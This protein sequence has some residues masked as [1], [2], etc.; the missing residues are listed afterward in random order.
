[1]SIPLGWRGVAILAYWGN[2]FEL[3]RSIE[4]YTWAARYGVY[5]YCVRMHRGKGNDEMV[6]TWICR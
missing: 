6:Q 4:I 2:G 1:M 3:D 5:V